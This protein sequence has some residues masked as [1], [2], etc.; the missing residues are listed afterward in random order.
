MKNYFFAIFMIAVQ[1]I[2][3]HAADKNIELSVAVQLNEKLAQIKQERLSVES[4]F[5]T[6]EAG[7][8]KK[9]AVSNCLQGLRS[10]KLQ[11]LSDIKRQELEI[12]DQ[13]RQIKADAAEKKAFEKSKKMAVNEQTNS[14]TEAANSNLEKTRKIVKQT[15][16]TDKSEASSLNDPLKNDPSQLAAKRSSAASQRVLEANA[17]QAASQKKAQYRAKKVNQSDAQEIKF[18]QKQLDAQARKSAIEKAA[19]EKKRKSEPLPIPT[20]Q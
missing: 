20:G 6:R 17:K 16:T 14:L 1:A 8:Y 12:N 3:T 13:K 10:E 11:A 5:I 2:N 18:N 15:N 19:A 9:F 7:C 4:S